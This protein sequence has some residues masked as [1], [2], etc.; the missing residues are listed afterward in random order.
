MTHTMPTTDEI[1]ACPSLRP[2]TEREWALVDEQSRRKAADAAFKAIKWQDANGGI[3]KRLPNG[4][5][6]FIKQYGDEI[7][8]VTFNAVAHDGANPLDAMKSS[9]LEAKKYA[10]D[11][12]RFARDMMR[13]VE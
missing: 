2:S 13:G 8:C 7:Y 12:L 3:R 4:T 10:D 11:V 6:A 5:T 9:L 1:M